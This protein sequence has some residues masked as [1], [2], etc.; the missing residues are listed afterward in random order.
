MSATVSNV[1]SENVK[2]TR[3][4]IAD[5]HE[6]FL[7]GL[8]SVIKEMP[9]I[10]V[11]TAVTRAD[12]VFEYLREYNKEVDIIILDINMPGTSGVEATVRLRKMYPEI[13]ILILTSHNEEGFITRVLQA[14]AMGYILKERGREELR[15]AIVTLNQNELYLGKAV[16][17]K[18]VDKQIYAQSPKPTLTKRETE[19]LKHIA[20]GKSSR[21]ISEEL[22]IAIPTVDTHRRNIIDKLDVKNIKELILYAIKH[23]YA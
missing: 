2:A 13:K 22:S 3:V 23:G 11:K 17:R 10:E 15:Q 7:E 16:Q 19:I 21:E 18:L 9:E 4:V 8:C 5:D 1:S 14:G 20:L 6:I 12:M